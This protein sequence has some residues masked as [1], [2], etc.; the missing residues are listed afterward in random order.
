MNCLYFIL[1]P[2]AFI[3][4]K[5]LFRYEVVNKKNLPSKG[6][7]IL[8]GNHKSN[9]DCIMVLASCNKKVHFLAKKELIDGKFGFFFKWMGIIPVDRKKRNKEAMNDARGV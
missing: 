8:V 7:Y 5:V 4:M 6:P 9:F 3:L 2:I 1:K